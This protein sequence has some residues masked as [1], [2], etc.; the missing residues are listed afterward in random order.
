M[1]QRA[2]ADVLELPRSAELHVGVLVVR[3][4][5]DAAVLLG[6]E[7]VVVERPGAARV[8]VV[9]QLDLWMMAVGNGHR[10]A[11]LA[12]RLAEEF[13]DRVDAA[14]L[15]LAGAVR[16]RGVGSE[17]TSELV[18]LLEIQVA[19]VAVLQLRD[20]FDVLE[21]FQTTLEVGEVGHAYLRTRSLDPRQHLL[22][23]Q[24]QALPAQL[25]RYSSHERVQDDAA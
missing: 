9:E 2:V 14:K 22:L 7:H 13:H 20:G 23:E 17:S 4:D 15:V 1:E 8:G 25:G 12:E 16:N 24:T 6:V 21:A 11:C 19:P 5:A 3:A 10:T 18:P